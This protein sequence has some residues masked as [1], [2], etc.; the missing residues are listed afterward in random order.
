MSDFAGAV[1]GF[2]LFYETEASTQ[3]VPIAPPR[4]PIEPCT[5]DSQIGNGGKGKA[6]CNNGGVGWTR[7]YTGTPGTVPVH[8]DPTNGEALTGKTAIDVWVELDVVSY[9]SGTTTTYRRSFEELGD[10]NTYFGGRKPAGLL[11]IGTL[12][13]GLGNEHGS[14]EA[15]TADIDFSDAIDRLFRGLLATEDLDGCE[16]RIYAAS[17]TARAAGS[18][19]R[20]LFRG[21]VQQTDF[22]SPLGVQLT[23][24]DVLFADGGPFGP[25]RQWP[26]LI[27]KTV[28]TNAPPDTL[29]QAL[30]VLYGEKSDE[31][32]VD[33]ATGEARSKGVIPLI[34][35]G[36]QRL[37]NAPT[38]GAYEQDMTIPQPVISAVSN[39]LPAPGQDGFHDTVY[40]WFAAQRISDGKIG[41]FANDPHTGTN[42]SPNVL[43]PAGEEHEEGTW[44]FIHFEFIDGEPTD[45]YQYIGFASTDPAYHPVTNP[46]VGTQIG[47]AIHD[48][49]TSDSYYERDDGRDASLAIK[50]TAARDPYE[51]DAYLV[52]WGAS[53]SILALYGS[54]MGGGVE[55]A[56]PQRALINGDA[57]GGID[58]LGPDW[59][60][61]PFDDRYV[62]YTGTDGVTYRLTMI[63]ARGPLSDDHKNGVVT[64]AVN[65]IGLEDVGDGSGLPLLKVHDVE[66]HWLENFILSHYTSGLWVTNSTAPKFADGTYKV[67]STRFATRQA[68]TATALGGD[69]LLAGWYIDTPAGILDY[70]T[71]FNRDTETQLGT[72]GHGQLTLGWDDPTADVSAWTPIDH[73]TDL[74]GP[75]QFTFVQERENQVVGFCDWDPDFEKFRVGP[76]EFQSLEGYSRFKNRWKTGEPIESTILSETAHLTWVLQQRLDRLKRGEIAGSVT[77]GMGLW[78][79]DVDS[80]AGILLTTIEGTGSLGYVKRA[81]T[82]RR[83]RLELR[84]RLVTYSLK[85]LRRS[86]TDQVFFPAAASMAWAGQAPTMVAP[87]QIGAGRITYTGQAPTLPATRLLSAGTFTFTG[88]APSLVVA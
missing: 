85:D 72:N 18:A 45:V 4:A 50:P 29:A 54:D 67:R 27:P 2:T 11:E 32:A 57:R 68:M 58:V 60:N 16:V 35:C 65:M 19:P 70:V 86:L 39:L 83:R 37:G 3:P 10:L 88:Q 42:T 81:M 53:Y 78:D 79:T 15:A 62:D 44:P 7:S 75:V 14:F 12:E 8:A 43:N 51:W 17:P 87:L 80:G 28:F 41:P 33:P 55:G 56:E 64:M 9:P 26:P 52:C 23:A 49:V 20:L 47:I 69:G 30:P 34:Y 40:L 66:Q 1:T 24:V 77:G 73:V 46:N 36:P 25:D 31:G 71:Q 61:W 74:F 13:H 21:I 48:G 5:P 82:L 22:G 84:S 59:P 63:F 6:G 38:P 76:I